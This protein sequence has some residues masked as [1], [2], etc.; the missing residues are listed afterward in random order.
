MIRNLPSQV[1]P[2]GETEPQPDLDDLVADKVSRHAGEIIDALIDQAKKGHYQAA[3]FLLTEFK[4]IRADLKDASSDE[5][6]KRL[7]AI[8]DLFEAE[9][10]KE[11]PGAKCVSADC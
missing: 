5:I 8:A 1:I 3:Q 2:P 6:D 11:L 7:S 10:K 9:F 4:R